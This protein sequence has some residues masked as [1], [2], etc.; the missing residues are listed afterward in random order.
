MTS[1]ESHIL[2]RLLRL[3]NKEKC[4]C[5]HCR[6]LR[7]SSLHHNALRTRVIGDMVILPKNLTAF[8]LPPASS[9]VDARQAELMQGQAHGW[10]V[11]SADRQNASILGNRIDSRPFTFLVQHFRIRRIEAAF[12]PHDAETIFDRAIGINLRAWRIDGFATGCRVPIRLGPP[13]LRDKESPFDVIV[14]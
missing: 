8:K 1:L 14:S 7:L 9:V 4:K 6:I 10:Y 2:G 12:Y 13:R 3:T 5:Q 11:G